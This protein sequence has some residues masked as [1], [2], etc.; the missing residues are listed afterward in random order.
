MYPSANGYS[1][2]GQPKEIE[3]VSG[4][5]MPVE[6]VPSP[7][8]G[9]PLL[10]LWRET[11]LD[12][13]EDGPGSWRGA[14]RCGRAKFDTSPAV[15]LTLGFGTALGFVSGCGTGRDMVRGSLT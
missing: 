15:G 11:T 10:P 2:G 14:A 12:L 13:I 8:L 1:S 3:W 9:M 5:L 4:I 7:P 6:V